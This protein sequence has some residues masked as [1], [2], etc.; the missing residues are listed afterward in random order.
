[1]TK[2]EWLNIVNKIDDEFIDELANDQLRRNQ[3]NE[4]IFSR[5]EVVVLKPQYY[6]PDSPKPGT[7]FKK[8]MIAV[9]AVICVAAAGIFIRANNKPET[10]SPNDSV[11]ISETS[12]GNSDNSDPI[13]LNEYLFKKYDSEKVKHYDKLKVYE[14]SLMQLDK[15]AFLDLFSETPTQNGTRY[16][17]DSE[18][19]SFAVYGNTKPESNE[20]GEQFIMS[21]VTY[22]KKGME[23]YP[24]ILNYFDKETN[25][26]IKTN[27]LDFATREE[28]EK[29]VC[30]SLSQF[31]DIEFQLTSRAVTSEEYSEASKK[32]SDIDWAFP[33]DFYCIDGIMTVDGLPVTYGKNTYLCDDVVTI[34]PTTFYAVY[35]EDGLV[36]FELNNVWNVGSVIS[37]SEILTLEDAE[38]IIAEQYPQAGRN[39]RQMIFSKAELFYRA[40]YTKDGLRLIP[41]WGFYVNDL[42]PKITVDAITGEML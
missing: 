42:D 25:E 8:A 4:K 29:T 6:R 26:H 38:K 14:C 31:G 30:E 7:A 37:E 40:Y 41:C 15:N 21:Y 16:T 18:S 12:T 13:Q 20:Y 34:A 1:M 17:T 11:S 3:I 23:S 9:A 19:G 35:T 32:V 33:K 36:D 28:I 2:D 27:V 24:L 39:P 10:M 22:L 5:R